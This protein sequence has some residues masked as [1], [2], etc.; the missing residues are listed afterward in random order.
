LHLT[1][2]KTWSNS[3]N[4]M[5]FGRNAD[6]YPAWTTSCYR[7]IHIYQYIDDLLYNIIS[8]HL[9]NPISDLYKRKSWGHKPCSYAIQCRQM[10]CIV[11][12]RKA[13]ITWQTRYL[14]CI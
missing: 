6:N 3:W 2:G 12:I 11:R 7:I 9:M 4:D 14:I 5:V 1:Q 8:S 13:V 10:N